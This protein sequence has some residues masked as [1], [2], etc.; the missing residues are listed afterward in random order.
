MGFEF[1][2]PED[3]LRITVGNLPHWF[4]PGV[5]CFVTFRTHDSLPAEVFQLWSRRR[6][7]WLQKHG[8]DTRTS[9]WSAELNGLPAAQ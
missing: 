3:D 6:E 4:Q 2:D 1:F 9:A 7:D 8:I 5:S